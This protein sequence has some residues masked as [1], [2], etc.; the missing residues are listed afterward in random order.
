MLWRREE[1]MRW[2]WRRYPCFLLRSRQ[3][4]L[5]R[6]AERMFGYSERWFALARTFSSFDAQPLFSLW[7]EDIGRDQAS[8]ESSRAVH[9]VPYSVRAWYLLP[10]TCQ[11]TTNP[12][13]CPHLADEDSHA[14]VGCRGVNGGLVIWGVQS[15]VQEVLIHWNLD[16]SG[17]SS[18]TGFASFLDS[19]HPQP[20]SLRKDAPHGES[21]QSL[22]RCIVDKS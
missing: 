22:D 6:S 18:S 17:H 2:P 14:L 15:T 1:E 12:S 16:D 21:Q 13:F 11:T 10:N 5:R 20:H 8:D 4:C 3:Y 7:Q 19:S 9:L